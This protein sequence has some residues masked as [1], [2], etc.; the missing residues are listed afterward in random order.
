MHLIP[1]HSSIQRKTCFLLL[2]CTARGPSYLAGI[3]CIGMLAGTVSSPEVC[4]L[5]PSQG[6][7]S[8]ATS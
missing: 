8:S 6:H 4:H 7:Y 5:S 3:V 1:T 2:Y